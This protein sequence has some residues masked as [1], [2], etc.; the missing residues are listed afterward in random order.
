MMK[1]DIIDWLKRKGILED[2]SIVK[3]EIRGETVYITIVSSLD[4]VS[5]YYYD[6]GKLLMVSGNDVHILDI[7]TMEGL[8]L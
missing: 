4:R 6:K 1:Q 7:K 8:P 3:V 5:S 2:D